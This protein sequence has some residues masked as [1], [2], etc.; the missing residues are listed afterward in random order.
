MQNE[1][2]TIIA[3]LPTLAEAEVIKLLLE[4]EGRKTEIQSTDS[5]NPHSGV[6][7]LVESDLVHRAIWILKNNGITDV[8]LGFLA[9]GELCKENQNEEYNDT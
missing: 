9:T 3:K 1:E 8:E 4:S 5:I 2:W 6:Y 7:L